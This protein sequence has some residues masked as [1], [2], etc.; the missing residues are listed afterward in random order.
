MF[1]RGTSNALRENESSLV[2]PV[3]SGW[4]KWHRAQREQCAAA[5][6]WEEELCP[7]RLWRRLRF[8]QVLVDSSWIAE[9]VD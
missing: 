7:Q 3:V 2:A 1:L 8:M 5:R 9:L 6:Q 4:R